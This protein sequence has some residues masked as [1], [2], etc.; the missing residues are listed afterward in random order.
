MADKG[1]MY[2]ERAIAKQKV[3]ENRCL[4]IAVSI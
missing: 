4:Q 2:I 3:S 1:K